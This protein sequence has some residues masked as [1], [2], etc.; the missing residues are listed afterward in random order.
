MREWSAGL[1]REGRKLDRQIR[2]T[3]L[4][5]IF[6]TYQFDWW[7]YINI[8]SF[9]H[10]KNWEGHVFIWER[11]DWRSRLDSVVIQ[12]NLTRLML[13]SSSCRSVDLRK[14]NVCRDNRFGFGQCR[15]YTYYIY[16]RMKTTFSV[17]NNIMWHWQVALQLSRKGC[18]YCY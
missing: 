3:N 7:W 14:L 15:R 16:T 9:I 2:S 17:F 8:S 11:S 1:R 13:V 10:R 5:Y 6:G 18:G 4:N 12:F